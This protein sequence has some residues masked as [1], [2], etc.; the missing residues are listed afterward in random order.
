[1]QGIDAVVIF[2]IGV[3]VWRSVYVKH[4]NIVFWQIAADRPDEAYEWMNERPDWTILDPKD[5]N[6][7]NLK[8]SPGLVG[9]FRLGVPSLGI[10]FIVFAEESSIDASQKDF[11]EMHS[12]NEVN[13]RFP[14]ISWLTMLYPVSAI[15]YIASF[16]ASLFSTLG[17]GFANLGYLLFLAGIFAGSFRAL[18]FIHRRQTLVAAVSVW[19]VGTVL[20]NL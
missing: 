13:T 16:D 3:Y 7:Q 12:N 8:Q 6:V 17:Y 5:P 15:L 14:W 18:G 20:S 11:I 2:F 10:I 4:G 19:L 9:R 1:M